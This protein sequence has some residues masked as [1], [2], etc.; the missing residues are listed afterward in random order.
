[1]PHVSSLPARVIHV[2]R[3]LESGQLFL[4]DMEVILVLRMV[5][6]QSLSR[7]YDLSWIDLE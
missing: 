4:V 7:I 6:N 1:V 5:E 2:V 3:V